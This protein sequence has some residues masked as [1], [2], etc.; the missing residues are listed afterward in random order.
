MPVGAATSEETTTGERQLRAV[1][2][3]QSEWRNQSEQQGSS[4]PSV[5]APWGDGTSVTS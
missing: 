4:P 2:G 1:R 5:S 3:R